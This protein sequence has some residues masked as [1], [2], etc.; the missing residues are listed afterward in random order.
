MNP[1][2]VSEALKCYHKAVFNPWKRSDAKWTSLV[3]LE[4]FNALAA[5]S[6]KQKWSDKSPVIPEM[7][8]VYKKNLD[9]EVRIVL[10]WDADNT[11]IDLHVLEPSGEEIYYGHQRSQT[12]GLLSFDVTT[13][14]GPE[15][16]LHKNAPK[17][18][19]KVMTNYFASHQQKL[20]GPVTV[21]VT[22]FTNWARDNET[23]QILSLRLE[24]AKDKVSV[25]SIEV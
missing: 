2:D 16:F 18:I 8:D 4:E 12:G 6:E 11:D 3:A 13:G 10:M 15:E 14:Y 20:T 5:W 25:G 24:K 22:V 17:G 21:T 23:S 1:D 19:Y 7:D 9:T